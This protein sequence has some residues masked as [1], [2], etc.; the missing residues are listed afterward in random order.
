[1][2]FDLIISGGTVYDGSGS[3]GF[4]ADVGLAGDRIGAVGDLSQAAAQRTIDAAGLAVCPGFID[5][6]THCH[7]DVDKDILHCDNL[8]RQGI[9][10]VVAGNCGGSGW[11]VAEHLAKVEREG[12]KSNYAMLVGHHTIRRIAMEGSD[13]PWPSHEQTVAMQDMMKQGLDEGA[14]GITVGYAR[15]DETFEEIVDVTRPA[16]EAGTIYASHIRSEGEALVQAV[17]EAIEVAHQTGIAVQISHLKTNGPAYWDKLD[18]V[19]EMIERAVDMG[20][21]VAA[22]RYPYIGWHGGSTNVMSPW[23]YEEARKRGGREHLKDPDIVEHFRREIAGKLAE[24]GGPDKLMFTSLKSPDPEVDGKTV[25]DLMDA[26]G[27]EEIDVALE[28]ERRNEESAIG[29][30]GFSMS[31]DNLRRILAHPLV[32]VGTDAHLEVFGRF[33]THPRNYGSYPRVLGRYVREEGIMSL[34]EAVEKM[35]ATPARRFGLGERGW[36]R[37]GCFADVVVFDPNTVIDNATFTNAHQYPTGMPY[38]IVNGQVAV[39]NEV[40][41]PGHHGRVLRRN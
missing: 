39:D 21:D 30:V 7:S 13:S 15:R 6:H 32:M 14:I 4:R 16:A 35:T 28:I 22:D 25:A 18:M 26:W 5:P 29:A 34:G 31:E 20:L 19:L 41:A 37:P 11:P 33:A 3:D 8:L 1:M 23:C 38:V 27:M 9:T 12:F 10:T 40:T 36:L 2:D 24:F 17:A